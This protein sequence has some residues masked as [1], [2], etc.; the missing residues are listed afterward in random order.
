FQ[1]KG[2]RHWYIAYFHHSV[3]HRESCRSPQ[4]ADAQRL[5]KTRLAAIE[6]R[7]FMPDEQRFTVESLLDAVEL[8]LKTRGA[9]ALVSFACHLKPVRT[10]FADMRAIDVASTHADRYIAQRQAD[11]RAR[12]VSSLA[13]RGQRAARILRAWRLRGRRG[14]AARPDR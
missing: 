9:K 1:N 10:F 12:A 5:L 3:E 7:R 13:A 8:H 6:T 2:S 11:G 4:K 14:A